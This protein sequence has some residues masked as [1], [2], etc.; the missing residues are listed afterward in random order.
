MKTVILTLLMFGIIINLHELGHFIFAKLFDVRVNEFSFGM[1]PKLFSKQKNETMY[2]IRL[3]PIGGY[4]A[5]DGEDGETD[6][7]KKLDGR[8][9]CDKKPW[10]KFLILSAGAGMNII[11]GFFIILGLTFNMDVLGTNQIL[12]VEENSSISEYL[13]PQD[14]ILTVNGNRTSSYNDVVFQLLRDEDGVIDVT[15]LRDNEKMTIESIPFT[16]EDHENG[17]Q[18][19]KL[20]MIFLGVQNSF[21]KTFDYAFN[22]T[23]SVIK[24]VWF[25]L[26]D[27]ITGRYGLKEISGPVGTAEIVSQAS[28]IGWSSLFSLLAFITLNVGVFNLLPIPALDGGRLF[29]LLIE[30]IFRKPVPQKYEAYVHATGMVLLLGLIAVITIKDIIYLFK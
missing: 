3:L 30:I 8:A 4:V 9:F 11:F 24:Q 16:L 5:M 2:S 17:R 6:E 1:G 28:K 23:I 19:V 14:K 15:V 20:D 26:F 27:I 18:I 25:S 22:W 12:K 13:K 10:Q 7:T 21:F 29:F